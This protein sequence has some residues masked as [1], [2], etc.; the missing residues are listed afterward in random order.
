MCLQKLPAFLSKCLSLKYLP[1][2]RFVI[3]GFSV[4][5]PVRSHKFYRRGLSPLRRRGM[6]PF[7]MFVRFASSLFVALYRLYPAKAQ[8]QFLENQ[9]HEACDLYNAALQERR[10]AWKV[11]RKSITYFDQANQLKQ[12]RA[13]GLLKLANFSCCQC[14][15]GWIRP[16]R[17]S[18]LYGIYQTFCLLLR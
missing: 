3:S 1:D 11:Y 7:L 10:D 17:R 15:A 13:A 2:V 16:S 4:A 9:L 14:S 5:H 18:S 8:V 6:R 12:I